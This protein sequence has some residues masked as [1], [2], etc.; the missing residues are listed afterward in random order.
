M[1]LIRLKPRSTATLVL[2]SLV[3]LL[4]FGWPLFWHSA[5][6]GESALGHTTDAP[7]LF[8]LLLPLLVAVVLAELAESAIDAK[9]ISLLGMLAAVSAALRALGPGTA[10]LE[11]GFFLLILAGRAFGAGFGFVLGSLSLLA[12]ALISG[13]VGP[14]M[15]FQMFACAWV[16]CFAGLLPRLGGRLEVLLLAAYSMVAGV[17]YGLVMNLW[18]WP[19]ATFGSD[20]SFVPGD[21]LLD[22][23]H[24]Y[25]LFVV[26]TSLGWDIPRGILCAV[27]VLVLGRPI[28]NA[29]RRTARKAAFDVPV[30][31]EAG[32]RSDG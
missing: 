9:V 11:P 17:L 22:N 21:S 5:Q 30:V 12:G 27:L 25:F 15:P 23:L 24:R 32:N 7:W 18:F 26:A 13:G 20:F 1:R 8:V 19:Y 14:W 6:G 3:G 28:L 16:G 4:A 31:F 10:G 2:A 29:F